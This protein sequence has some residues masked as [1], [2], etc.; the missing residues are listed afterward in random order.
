MSLPTREQALNTLTSHV[1][2]DYQILHAKMVASAMEAWAKVLNKSRNH[3]SIDPELWYITGLLHD[4]DYY[5]FP[6]QHPSKSLEWFK[7]WGYPDELIHAVEAHAFNYNGFTTKPNTKMAAALIACDEMSGLI[8]A[9]SLM[10]PEGYLGMEVKGV[11]KRMK[12]KGFAAKINREDI[13]YGVDKFGV[14]IED[15]IQLLI[16]TFKNL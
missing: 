4:L 3:D 1:K 15:H 11:K 12:D 13:Y 16:D 6:E 7:E 10:R 8:Y 9:Y 5:E 14:S 2:D